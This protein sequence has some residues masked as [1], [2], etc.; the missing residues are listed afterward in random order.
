MP[1]AAAMADRPPRARRT[2]RTIA[3]SAHREEV[4]GDRVRRARRRADRH[5]I[6]EPRVWRRPGLEGGRRAEVV[7]RR[8]HGLARLEPRQHFGRARAHAAVAHV[9]ESAVLRAEGVAR[10]EERAPVGAHELPVGAARQYLAGQTLTLEMA[11]GD[12]YDASLAQG[13]HAHADGR[14]DLH[15]G[16]EEP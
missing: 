14:S 16:T 7:A 10:L 13:R 4:E 6:V 11:A 2:G 5:E 3:G 15:H 12:G 8:L 1:T 9:H